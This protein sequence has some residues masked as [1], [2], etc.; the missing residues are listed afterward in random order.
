MRT[1]YPHERLWTVAALSILLAGCQQAD[2]VLPFEL[3]GDE[4]ATI[5]IGQNGGTVTVPPTIS[6]EFPA[7]SLSGSTAVTVVPRISGPF[8]NDAGTAVPGT[9]FDIGPVG[10]TLINPAEVEI[11]VDPALLDASDAVRLSVAVQR[12]DGSVATFDATYDVTNGVL[13]AELDELGPIAAV[14]TLDAIPLG[15]EAPPSLGGGS[16]PSP[17]PPVAGG[18][19][20]AQFGGIDFVAACAPEGRQCFSSGLIRL[21]ADEVVQRRMG[22]DLWFLNPTV[23]ASLEFLSFDQFGIPNQVFGSVS[24]DGNVRAKFN[25]AVSSYEME[26]G[27]ST[28]PGANPQPTG[29]TITGNLMTMDQTTTSSGNVEFNE[30]FEFGITGIGTTEM[31][32][33]EV[34][35]EIEFDNEDGSVEIGIII[36]HVRLRVPQS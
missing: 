27:A 11:A 2:Q 25:S 32:T 7:G 26:D 10:T 16:V 20:P 34:E 23:S 8:P 31:M 3:S 21:W 28:G 15:V 17:A 1:K 18:P 22:E 24:V 35:A 6:L 33:I 30:T 9:A 29:L 4:G 14:I 36:A 5:T 13:V 19:Q 12:E